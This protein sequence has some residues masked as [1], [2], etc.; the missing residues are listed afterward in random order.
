MPASAKGLKENFNWFALLV[1]AALMT[2]GVLNLSNAD[3]YS[4]ANQHKVQLIWMIVGTVIAVVLSQ[5]DHIIHEKLA[6][7]AY[8]LC[9]VALIA[10]S[11]WGEERNNSRR[12]FVLAGVGLQPSE[13]IKLA[14]ILIVARFFSQARVSERYTLRQLWQPG[15]LVAIPFLVILKQPD[16]GTALLVGFVGV[17]MALYEGL[18]TRSLLLALGIILFVIP[19]SWKY[20][21]LPGQKDRVL[22]WLNPQVLKMDKRNP[23]R[24]DRTIQPRMAKWAVGSGRFFGKGSRKG[25][26]TR[27]KYLP[28]IHN[29][30]SLAVFAEEHG[31]AGCTLLLG[32]FYIL[33][34]WIFRVSAYA[35]T[36][37]GAQLAFGVGAMIFWQ[38][39]INIGMVTGLLPV[40]GLPLPFMSYGGSSLLT[41]MLGLGMVWNVSLQR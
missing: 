3:F 11:V 31:F 21:I 1:T 5:I 12:W 2:I 35:K 29:D 17:S 25:T 4:G 37:F 28:E 27:L 38:V 8:V 32:L 30:F 16:L 20:V 39:T 9:A 33:V 34:I 36:K 7:I 13:F 26:Q 10:V 14:T 15:L 19:V 23:R 24:Y 18:Q 41:T 40:V 6:W 22:A